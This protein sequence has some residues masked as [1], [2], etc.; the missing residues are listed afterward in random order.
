LACCAI[1]WESLRTAFFATVFLGSGLLFLAM[2]FASAATGGGIIIAYTAKHEGLL[3][4]PT[5]TFARAVTYEIMN[6]YA[7]K[8]AA[9]RKFTLR[10]RFPRLKYKSW[11]WVSQDYLRF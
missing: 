7:V 8:M 1:A 10:P 4:S 9:V 5:F 6:L 3:G 11:L 2:L